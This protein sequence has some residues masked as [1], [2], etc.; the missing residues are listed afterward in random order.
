[1]NLLKL[2]I[3]IKDKSLCPR[4][5]AIVVDNVKIKPSP[6]YIRSRLET[7]GIRTINNI[8]DITNYLMLELGQPMHTFD[9]DKIKGARMILRSSRENEKITTLDGQVRALPKDTIVIQDSSRL[10]DLCGIMGGENSRVTSRTK[11]VVIF[12]QAYDPHKI[13]KTTQ[14]LAFRTDAAARFEKGIDPEGILPALKR[15]V[16]LA[17]ETAG[18]KIASELVDI[19]SKKQV[20]PKIRLSFEKL[21]GYLGIDLPD[22]KA[23][24]LLSYLGFKVKTSVSSLGAQTPSWRT[25]DIEDDVDLIEEIAR[26]YGYH[27]LPSRLP[28]GETP[29][30]SE[31]QLEQVIELKKAL[32]FLGLTEIIS[33]SII[34]KKLLALTKTAPTK[35]VELANPLSENWQYMRPSLVPSLL[36]VVSQNSNTNAYLKLFEVAKTYIAQKNDLP[37]QDLMLSIVLSGED[38]YKAKGIVENVLKILKRQG[39][40]QIPSKNNPL[41][42]ENQTAEIKAGEQI[43]GMVGEVNPE[44]VDYFKIGNRFAAAEI[45]LSKILQLPTILPSYHPIPK[46]PPV[47]EDISAI[48]AKAAPIAEIV[49]TIEKASTLAKK[50]EV[51]DIFQDEKIGQD[52]RS[53]TIRITYQKSTTTPSQEEVAEQKARIVE[54]LEKDFR[55]KI[56]SQ[57][58]NSTVKSTYNQHIKARP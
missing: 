18:A 16:F 7:C 56:R 47:I 19:Y 15:A 29:Q 4:F 34:P 55:A 41:F 3:L 30:K 48:F 39:K 42:S 10:I 23:V 35:A 52:K 31:S 58:T 1:M 57:A 38:F 8:V 37:R 51:I 12:V 46:Y 43:V 21:N 24:Q 25:T 13:R 45:N 28:Q 2:D 36:E 5:T 20:A 54:A 27:K 50:V 6:A 32:K 11:K 53:I 17:K 40:W 9:Y 22:T 14:A 49:E 33:Y 44:I 26:L